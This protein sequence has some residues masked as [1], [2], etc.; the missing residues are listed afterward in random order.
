VVFDQVL[1]G[2][3]APVRLKMEQSDETLAFLMAHDTD[4][5]NRWEVRKRRGRE[6]Y[7]VRGGEAGDM[8]PTSAARPAVTR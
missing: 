1:R 4:S 8:F 3:S 5:F 6:G 7:G 2:F